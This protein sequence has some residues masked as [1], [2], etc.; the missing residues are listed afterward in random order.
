MAHPNTQREP[1]LQERHDAFWAAPSF[2]CQSTPTLLMKRNSVHET[3]Q[4]EIER[5]LARRAA[6]V[7]RERGR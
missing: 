4:R 7:L 2:D 1:S 6:N 5:V 3:D